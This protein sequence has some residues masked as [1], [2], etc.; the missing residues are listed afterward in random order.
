MG[1]ILQT[2]LLIHDYLG[3]VSGLFRFKSFTAFG[4]RANYDNR[5]QN[6]VF[7]NRRDKHS[8]GCRPIVNDIL[9]MKRI[10]YAHLRSDSFILLRPSSRFLTVLWHHRSAVCYWGNSPW[11]QRLKPVSL[12]FPW[13]NNLPLLVYQRPQYSNL[14]LDLM[15]ETEAV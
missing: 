11:H 1:N 6:V 15:L 8:D 5:N 3:S 9:F 7:L 4:C 10:R 2:C 14:I 12:L 13:P